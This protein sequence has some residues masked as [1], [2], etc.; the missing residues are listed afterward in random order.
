MQHD[1]TF[2]RQSLTD[3]KISLQHLVIRNI[4][5]LA[6]HISSAHANKVCSAHGFISRSRYTQYETVNANCDNFSTCVPTSQSYMVNYNCSYDDDYNYN[7]G[8]N[9]NINDDNTILLR[10]WGYCCNE[11]T[12]E[13]KFCLI[14]CQDI[15]T[16]VRNPL[17]V[18]VLFLL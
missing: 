10:I 7:C 13:S 17:P 15:W 2:M 18:P 3:K 12:C 8:T 11:K 16:F 9:N 1:V 5:S 6:K 14:A 4:W